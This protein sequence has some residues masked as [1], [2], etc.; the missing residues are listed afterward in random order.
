MVQPKRWDTHVPDDDDRAMS[1][2]Q[3]LDLLVD[4]R[5]SWHA[6]AACRGETNVMF[7]D[8]VRAAAFC[9]RCVVLEQ[10]R[11]QAMRTEERFGTWGGVSLGGDRMS[12]NVRAS[13]AV[14]VA[15]DVAQRVGWFTAGMV[16]RDNDLHRAT[17]HRALIAL[18]GSGELERRTTGRGS[19][20]RRST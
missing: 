20:F 9:R 2:E 18:W 14:Q 7:N 6:R 1:D 16:A 17:V 19:H 13:V 4:L 12:D 11:A 15:V 3:I 10:C 5:P 8:P